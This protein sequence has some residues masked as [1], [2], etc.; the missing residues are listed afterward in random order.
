[1][2]RTNGWI[3]FWFAVGGF[4]V[5]F[6]IDLLVRRSTHPIAAHLWPIIRIAPYSGMAILSLC[7]LAQLIFAV[8]ISK[9]FAGAEP[10]DK[11]RRALT[12]MAVVV[13]VSI[14]FWVAVVYLLARWLG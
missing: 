10:T 6:G 2:I 4:L 1:M 8:P 11:D 12:Q 14:V 5:T 13:P 9:G 7:G 3:M